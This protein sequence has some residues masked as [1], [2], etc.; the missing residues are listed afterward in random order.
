MRR[1]GAPRAP[2]IHDSVIGKYAFRQAPLRG[3]AQEGRGK[4][5]SPAGCVL[6][7]APA[8]FS[9]QRPA[10]EGDRDEE[11]GRSAERVGGGLSAVRSGGSRRCVRAWSRPSRK[12]LRRRCFMAPF[13]VGVGRLRSLTHSP[14]TPTGRGDGRA[15]APSARQHGGPSGQT[16]PQVPNGPFRGSEVAWAWS[17]R[18]GLR[19]SDAHP[20]GRRRPPTTREHTATTWL[21]H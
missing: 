18:H 4:S 8:T 6:D 11:N 21:K 20:A 15:G 1:A 7:A 2:P 9:R 16:E 5:I 14:C 10:T 3:L 19:P 13:S 17:C 12:R